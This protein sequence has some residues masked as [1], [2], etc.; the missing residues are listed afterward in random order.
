MMGALANLGE[1]ALLDLGIYGGLQALEYGLGPAGLDIMVG[2]GLGL[3]AI[4]IPVA[5]GGG[6]LAVGLLGYEAYACRNAA[7][8]P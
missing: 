5:I 6:L 8:P 2:G 7:Y 4:G 1:H 3:S